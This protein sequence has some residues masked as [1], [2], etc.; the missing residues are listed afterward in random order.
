MSTERLLFKENSY[1]YLSARTR[2]PLLMSGSEYYVYAVFRRNGIFIKRDSYMQAEEGVDIPLSKFRTGDLV[3][4]KTK[5]NRISH[6]GIYMGEG[7]F[8]HSSKTKKGIYISNLSSGFFKKRFV[9]ARRILV[10]ENTRL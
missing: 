2:L 9:K 10:S 5:G 7:N 8:M 6:V 1:I 4:F 3:F